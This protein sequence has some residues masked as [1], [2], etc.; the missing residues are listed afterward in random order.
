[1]NTI[2]NST[3]L[4]ISERSGIYHVEAPNVSL[5]NASISDLIES[6]IIS[7]NHESII[8]LTIFQGNKKSGKSLF[9]IHK[10]NDLWYDSEEKLL[11]QEKIEEYLQELSIM[12]SSFI[13]ETPTELQNKQLDS[14]IKN[15]VYSLV[16]EDN[17]ANRIEYNISGM[18]K[19]ISD[20]DLKN[21][22]HF[23]VT[24]TGHAGSYIVKK[25]FY[26]L[27]NRKFD[28]LKTP[29]LENLEKN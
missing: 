3:Y 8:A 27:F 25:E 13:I 12:K 23:I 18:V 20:L 17:K 14:H 21:E 5:E 26:E 28:N 11:S 15:P 19:E 22:D 29:A 1:M 16:F 9:N 6:Q 7:I 24:A 10:N 2:D 4:K